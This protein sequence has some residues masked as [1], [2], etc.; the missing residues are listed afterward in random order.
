MGVTSTLMGA[1]VMRLRRSFTVGY[2][3][4]KLTVGW[5]TG[6]SSKMIRFLAAILWPADKMDYTNLQFS[7][8][9]GKEVEL[10]LVHL[11]YHFVDLNRAL[12]KHTNYALQAAVRQ[13]R[14]PGEIPELVFWAYQKL[15][16]TGMVLEDVNPEWGAL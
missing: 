8:Y 14:A 6:S 5:G 15:D 12:R 2:I 10:P 9:S 1:L 13:L 11:H 16:E 7:G 4:R 3:R